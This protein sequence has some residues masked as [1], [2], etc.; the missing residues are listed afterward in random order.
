MLLSTA[1][2]AAAGHEGLMRTVFL[3]FG[4][5][6][7]VVFIVLWVG[8]GILTKKQDELRHKSH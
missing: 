6:W 2:A 4:A 1:T 7:V 3:V 5:F 8:L